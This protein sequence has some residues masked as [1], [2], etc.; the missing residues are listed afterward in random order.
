MM[1]RPRRTTYASQLSLVPCPRRGLGTRQPLRLRPRRRIARDD[2]ARHWWIDRA[3][4]PR[5]DETI[6][7]L[8]H[9]ASARLDQPTNHSSAS[10]ANA[11]AS[12]LFARW[13]LLG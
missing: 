11:N 9:R 2:Q 1:G 4:R 7:A 5:V 6:A 13:F 3:G 8:G 10:G 12:A